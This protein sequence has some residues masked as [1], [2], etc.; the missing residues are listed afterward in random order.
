[1]N[2]RYLL[3]VVLMELFIFHFSSLFAKNEGKIN[4]SEMTQDLQDFF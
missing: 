1:M 3:K 2:N 4:I